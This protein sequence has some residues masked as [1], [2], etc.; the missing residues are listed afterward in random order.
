M[1]R[2]DL[3]PHEWKMPRTS[4]Q[5]VDGNKMELRGKGGLLSEI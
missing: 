2:D 3:K 4:V 5:R 1:R